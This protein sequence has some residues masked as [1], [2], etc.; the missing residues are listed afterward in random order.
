[1][2]KIR[3]LST[4][5]ILCLLFTI[6]AGTESAF[7]DTIFAQKTVEQREFPNATKDKDEEPVTLG[8][9]ACLI[10]AKTGYVIYGV[11]EHEKN[12][13][14]STT[15]IMT[16]LLA[17][18]NLKLDDTVTVDQDAAEAGGSQLYLNPGEEMTVED[19]LYGMMLPSAN[20][21]AVA[22]GK[23]MA[24]TVKDFAKMMNEKAESIGALDSNFANPNGLPN[25]NHYTTAYDLALIAKEAMKYEDFRKVVST[26]QYT[27]AKNNL[28]GSRLIHNRNRLLYNINRKV[29]AYGETKSIKYDGVTGI[30]T[31]YTDAARFCLVGSAE[32]NGTELIAVTMKSEDMNGYQDVVSMLD[33]G[34]NNYKTIQVKKEGAAVKNIE[35]DGGEDKYAKAAVK[36]GL[37]VTV[38]VDADKSDIQLKEEYKE[39]NAPYDAGIDG[40]MIKA[41]Y[42][43]NN[44]GEAQVTIT[45]AMAESSLLDDIMTGKG[46]FGILWKVLLVLVIL[47]VAIF[48]L[49]TI[50]QNRRRR[51]R[52][53]RR[54]AS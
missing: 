20:D 25:K 18:E 19:L 14:A 13:P 32:R 51:K 38:P 28:V 47:V 1:M 41:Y 17:M 16:G 21:A 4:L 40:G 30:K 6:G 3:V 36:N 5:M 2:N 31:G 35:V 24:P 15:K 27:I 39:I 52:R 10:D 46:F 49:R 37:Y 44:I 29:K 33:Y 11:D 26:Y 9:A 45:K 54:R 34:F 7:K 48:I 8:T 22:L 43:G 12:Y 23:A 53:R 50:N 42:N